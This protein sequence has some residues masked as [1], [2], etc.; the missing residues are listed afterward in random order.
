MKQ[1]HINK[2][3]RG[4]PAGPFSF[5][6]QVINREGAAALAPEFVKG[7]AALLADSYVARQFAP[8]IKNGSEMELLN[9][10]GECSPGNFHKLKTQLIEKDVE[11]LV[12]AGGGKAMD[13]AKYL[14]REIKGLNLIN[15]PTSAATCAAFTPV[16]V[17]YGEKGVYMDTLDTVCPDVILLDYSIFC[18][19]PMPFFAAGAVDSLAKYY[20][21]AAY[22][23]NIASAAPQDKFILETA[24]LFHARLKD[25]IL[26][27][28]TDPGYGVKMELTDLIIAESGRLS[29]MAGETPTAGLAHAVAHA[30]T[31]SAGAKQFLHGEHV[32]AGLV[33][34]ETYL[35]NGERLR[36]LEALLGI[37]ELPAS[38]PGIGVESGELAVF[39]SLYEAIVRREKIYIPDRAE[40]VYNI[41]E[42][43]Y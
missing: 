20:E 28:W 42:S 36:E 14:K 35:K 18:G 40:N 38:L 26:K 33:I 32:A 24:G 31:V 34:Q 23:E 19:L 3:P 6:G 15:I 43:Q 30:V 13:T 9:F 5:P 25:L 39:K 16:S 7:K 17:L 11:T 2:G 1:R 27:K 37:M 12:A 10:A 41:I 22:C 21:C 29:C 4:T 8:A